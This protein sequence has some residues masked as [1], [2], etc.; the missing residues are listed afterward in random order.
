M[1]FSVM[2][3]TCEGS[4]VD[5]QRTQNVTSTNYKYD[6]ICQHEQIYEVRIYVH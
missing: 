2:Y 5:A 4:K 6:T 1:V 3:T